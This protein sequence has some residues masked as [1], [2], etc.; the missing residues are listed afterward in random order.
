MA[1]RDAESGRLLAPPSAGQ[2]QPL[3]GPGPGNVCTKRRWC[4]VVGCAVAAA[5]VAAVAIVVVVT[6]SDD[7]V[8]CRPQCAYQ[9]LPPPGSHRLIVHPGPVGGSGVAYRDVQSHLYAVSVAPADGSAAAVD[10]FVYNTPNEAPTVVGVGESTH[11]AMFDIDPGTP[12]VV[13]VTVLD[14]GMQ[15]VTTAAVTPDRYDGT[16]MPTPG[17]SDQVTVRLHQ[18]GHYYVNVNGFQGSHDTPLFLFVERPEGDISMPCGNTLVGVPSAPADTDATTNGGL[19]Y[20]GRGFHQTGIINVAA[21][22]TVYL[23]PGAYV[24]GSIN[25]AEVKSL[26]IRGR[27]VLC[28]QALIVVDPA[29][30]AY[31]PDPYRYNGINL[32]KGLGPATWALVE[33]ITVQKPPG[34]TTNFAQTYSNV[35]LMHFKAVA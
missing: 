14:A 17:R 24:N 22:A 20:F 10:A 4:A 32:G 33:G 29:N 3:H 26:V 16:A 9:R 1:T 30:P 35:Q 25:A 18:P 5:V 7:A 31:Q 12:V 13:T 19:L 8:A 11:F 6:R 27:G 21:D 15:P 34:Y 23:A 28:G 2:T